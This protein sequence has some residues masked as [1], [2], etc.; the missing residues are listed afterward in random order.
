[1]QINIH[2]AKTHLSSLI[3]RVEAGEEVIIARSGKPVAKLVS[4]A[5]PKAVRQPGTARGEIIVSDD[6]DSPLPDD[7][8]RDFHS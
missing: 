3:E 8:L 4:L 1:M 2:E 7:I 5:P 6:F